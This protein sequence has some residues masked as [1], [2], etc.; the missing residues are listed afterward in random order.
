MRDTYIEGDMADEYL[1]EISII[2][3]KIS[4]SFISDLADLL[5]PF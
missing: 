3:P 2:F 1:E 4:Q 5:N